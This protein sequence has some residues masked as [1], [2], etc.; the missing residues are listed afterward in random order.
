[1]T[2]FGTFW[3]RFL[4]KNAL[5][6][7]VD[8]KYW[9]PNLGEQKEAL[10]LWLI[11]VSSAIFITEIKVA[12]ADSG[13]LVVPDDYPTIASALGNAT[14][15]DTIFMKRGTY[16]GPRNQTL[17]IDKAISIIGE[18]PKDTILNL[19]PNYTEWSICTQIFRSDPD[20]IRIEANDVRLLNLTL[21]FIGEIRVTGDR[22]QIMYNNVSSHSTVRGIVING[23]NCTITSNSILGQITLKGSSHTIQQN[24]F[25]CL[26][27]Q[28]TSSC[29]IDSN[30]LKFFYLNSSHNNIVSRNSINTVNLAY[31]I[32][33][34]NS[35]YNIFHDNKVTVTIWNNNLRLTMSQNNTFY[36]N[37]FI[38]ADDDP[39]VI[40]DATSTNIWDNGTTGNYWSNYNGTDND[41]NG[42][43]DLP[44]I[45]NENNQDNYPLMNT[46]D[47]EAIPEFPPWIILPILITTTLAAIIGKQ[48]LIKNCQ[49]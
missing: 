23:Y 40:L 47:I 9:V 24:D 11:F 29:I 12:E 49:A 3:S 32:D 46:A 39:H 13:T 42:I 7:I 10:I 34:S 17:V 44:Y 33:M 18:D 43:G 38:D 4:D 5:I 22:V 1:L 25:Y 30:T 19:H 21:D 41:G 15:G 2:R 27:L 45:I 8:S 37:A 14:D 16:D 20:A 36:N 26:R 31:A 28:S 35:N 6:L 48:R